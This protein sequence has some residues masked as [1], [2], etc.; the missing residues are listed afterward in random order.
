MMFGN[1][2]DSIDSAMRDAYLSGYYH[3]AFEIQ[4]GVGIGWNFATLD[5]RRISKVINAPWAAD[6]KNFSERVWGNRQR[7]VN[8]LHTE[9]TRN[10][11]LGQD[12]QKAI[13]AIA[14]KMNVSKNN[15][16]RLVMTEEA[17]FSSAA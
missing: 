3:T 4:K 9:L 5:E 11:M 8:E 13:D 1:Q 2:L 12:P 10:I 15:A 7:L 14:K 6:G 16:G 17:F